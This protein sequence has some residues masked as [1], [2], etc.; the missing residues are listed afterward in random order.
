MQNGESKGPS[1]NES[2][3]NTLVWYIY[4][5]THAMHALLVMFGSALCCRRHSTIIENPLPAGP[6]RTL[7]PSCSRK[8]KHSDARIIMRV[9]PLDFPNI[10]DCNIPH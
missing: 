10:T 9:I 2:V 6:M 8:N 7:S 1:V 5:S 3:Y 4:V